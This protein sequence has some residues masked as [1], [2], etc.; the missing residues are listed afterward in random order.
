MT[1]TRNRS[2]STGLPSAKAARGVPV[3]RKYSIR[4]PI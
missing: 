3:G 4:A 2:S 1:G